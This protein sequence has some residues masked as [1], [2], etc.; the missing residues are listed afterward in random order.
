M[1]DIDKH[2]E[3][4]LSETAPRATPRKDR[5]EA[6]YASLHNEWYAA[7][8][9]NRRKRRYLVSGIAASLVAAFLAITH[10]DNIVGE[11]ALPPDALLARSVGTGTTV[12]DQPIEGAIPVNAPLRFDSGDTIATGANGA[13]A[14]AW[15]TSGSL[16]LA[17]ASVV[18]LVD[19]KHIRLTAGTMY[20]DSNSYNSP[21]T[22]TIEVETRYGMI[23]HVGTQ[24]FAHVGRST[25]TIAVR[26][27]QVTFRNASKEVLVKSGESARFDSHLTASIS[28][29][30]ATDKSWE[31]VTGIA[32]NRN[33]D[34]QSTLQIIGWLGRE[35]GL[36]I[37]FGD[38]RTR[39]FVRKDRIRGIGEIE[40][41]TAM[42]VI[43]LTAGLTFDIE[44]GTIRITMK[45]E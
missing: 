5:R 44:D 16:R 22:T 21:T 31:W 29:I 35:T 36:T 26:E 45:D 23:N 40:P 37:E 3:D 19:A 14:I 12:N 4:L 32:P 41:L 24:F 25:A 15:G 42:K 2:I 27:G 43:P 6:A 33:V 11:R 13:V 18:T 39:E 1:N 34:G 17:G 9:Q 7:I 28:P 10:I 8:R 20:Y 38:E 30:T